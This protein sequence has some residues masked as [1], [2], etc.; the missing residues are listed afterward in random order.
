MKRVGLCLVVFLVLIG[1]A[2]A[3]KTDI[4]FSSDKFDVIVILKEEP[5]KG[6]FE[7]ASGEGKKSFLEEKKIGIK[8]KQE[9]VLSKFDKGFGVTAGGK[10]RFHKFSTIAGFAGEIT[11]EEFDLLMN[12]PDVEGVYLNREFSVAL[13]DT[14]ALINSTQ[15]NNMTQNHTTSLKGAGQTVCV[16]DTGIDYDHV[17]LG[18]GLGNRVL[19]GYDFINSDNDPMDDHG[20]GTHVAGIIGSND[21]IYHGVAPEVNFVALKACNAAGSCDGT[22]MLSSIDWCN[23]N[24]SV[25][26]ITVISMSIGDSASYTAATCPSTFDAVLATTKSLG[27]T[28]VASTGNDYYKT[29]I[30]LPACAPNATSVGSV[31]K[32]DAIPSYSNSGNLLEL[33][34]PGGTS[35]VQITSLDNGGGYTTMYGT[36]MAAP[37]VSG[38]IVLLNQYHKLVNGSYYTPT[39]VVAILKNTGKNVTDTGNN[40]VTPRIQVDIALFSIDNTA[41]SAAY[42]TTNGTNISYD[43]FTVQ[44]NASES[45]DAILEFNGTN[46]TMDKMSNA[47][48][49]KTVTD[50]IKGN[51]SYAVY[52]S[53]LAGNDGGILD[54]YV[55]GVNNTAP[56]ITYYVPAD[57]NVSVLE[58]SYLFF[59]HTSSDADGDTLSYNWYLNGS[60]Q[61]T[62]AYWNFTPG[63]A[64]AGAYEVLLLVSDG[65]LNDTQT[66]N[67][68]VNDTNCAPVVFITAPSNGS[69]VQLGESVS[70]T[71]NTSDPENNVLLYNWTFGD[72]DSSNS[73]NTSH[74][75]STAGN[76]TVVLTAN[77]TELAGNDSVQITVA[78]TIAPSVSISS[79]SSL[80]WYGNNFAVTVNATDNGAGVNSTSYRVLNSAGANVTAW[81]NMSLSSGFYTAT[82]LIAWLSDAANYTL[83]I[84][85]TDNGGYSN[86]TVNVTFHVDNTNPVIN[87]VTVSGVTSSGGTLTVNV[88]DALSG[89]ASCNYTNAG[90]GNLA[91][92]SGLYTA[93]MSGL[94]SSLGYTVSVTCADAAGNSDT[95][96]K[97]FTT[98]AEDTTTTSSS[99]GGGGGAGSTTAV[100]AGEK[101][102]FFYSTMAAGTKYDLTFTNS[103]LPFTVMSMTPSVSKSSVNIEVTTTTS[104]PTGAGGGVYKYLSIVLSNIESTEV[105]RPKIE[106]KV[107]KS[108][109]TDN[110]YDPNTVKLQ[111]Y[112]SGWNALA[113]TQ[114][115]SDADYYHYSATTPG[116][117][118][119][120]ITAEAVATPAAEP[121]FGVTATEEAPKELG[122]LTGALSTDTRKN[123]TALLEEEKA[124][125][126][127]MY[128][129]LVIPLA[130]IFLVVLYYVKRKKT[131]SKVVPVKTPATKNLGQKKGEIVGHLVDSHNKEKEEAEKRLGFKQ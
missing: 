93:T 37:H 68:T 119:F 36:S 106:F 69:T 114:T 124:V 3:V 117:S 31:G 98:S 110:G 91:L 7:V 46:Y 27:I 112:D 26:N 42:L 66:W 101:K 80:S 17:S 116:F 24:A 25:Y 35:T 34:A 78:D 121:S 129:L 33:L 9:K 87:N 95:D 22:A 44:I 73:T 76:Y 105:G 67:L 29:G 45:V 81:T 55:I 97:S 18:S 49:Q 52:F 123:A 41:P 83:I 92:S 99:S 75:Y 40:N 12:D 88:T 63:C 103:N 43:Y 82:F 5:V 108:W 4:D 53:D 70:F 11:A 122:E 13:A 77:D 79:P 60:S 1:S 107:P 32:D 19:G 28:F 113:T 56:N 102:S 16:I 71:T 57:G 54:G 50:L 58:N 20:H 85:A 109:F 72:G 94:T 96:S 51:Y 130:V 74:T 30:S 89:V 90:S 125:S 64:D 6:K 126:Y 14:T 48:Y 111:R 84:N 15:V 128:L 47:V 39:E 131:P 23:D 100:P 8:D 120:A 38:A 2:L 62:D 127:Q 10:E 65:F 86:T 61:S 21:S 115:S 104:P 59:N 118:Y